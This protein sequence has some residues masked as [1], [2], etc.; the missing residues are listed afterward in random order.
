MWH[1]SALTFAERLPHGPGHLALDLAQLCP[2]KR[3]VRGGNVRTYRMPMAILVPGVTDDSYSRFGED[4]HTP[5]RMPSSA[6]G[7][8]LQR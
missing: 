3:V 2:G 8:G 7:G 6:A 1:G 5:V 4:A